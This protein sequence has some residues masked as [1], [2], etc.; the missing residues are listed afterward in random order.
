[1]KLS[2]RNTRGSLGDDDRLSIAGSEV[3]RYST[4]G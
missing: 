2:R 1:V 4:A 3:R